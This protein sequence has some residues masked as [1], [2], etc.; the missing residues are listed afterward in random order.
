[1]TPSDVYQTATVMR[2]ELIKYL[3]G[4]RLLAIVLLT[5]LISAI[6]LVVPPAVGSSC[7]NDP[8]QFALHMLGFLGT[9]STVSASISVPLLSVLSATFFGADAIVSEYESRTGYFL[10][11]HPIRKTTIFTG[12]FLASALVSAATIGLF[13][14]IAAA[15]VQIVDGSVPMTIGVSYAYA[16]AYLLAILAVAYFF[17]SVMPSSVYALVLTFF[18]FFLILPVIDAV[19][20]VA[21]FKPWFSVTFA[22]LISQYVFQTPYPSDTVL[23]TTAASLA[24]YYPAVQLSLAVIATYFVVAFAAGAFLTQRR[25]M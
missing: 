25:E 24:A 17:S 16:L 5:V 9:G 14:V 6:L 20:S 4:R 21:H 12:K 3:R 10:F 22:S 7:P 11:T 19:A 23:N 8:T 13:Y 2:Y 18:T 15:S 1:M